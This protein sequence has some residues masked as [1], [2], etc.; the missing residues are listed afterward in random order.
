MNAILEKHHEKANRDRSSAPRSSHFE[1]D[2]RF[3]QLVTKP[4]CIGIAGQGL[5]RDWPT[6]HSWK[7]CRRCKT[8]DPPRCTARVLVTSHAFA[9]RASA[10]DALR[11]FKVGA[12]L[13]RQYLG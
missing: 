1:R 6:G 9:S 2:A 5:R 13:R 10:R 7:R 4:G 3:A 12:Q 8:T 11:F